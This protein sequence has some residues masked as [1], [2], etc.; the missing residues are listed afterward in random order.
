MRRHD[1]VPVRSPTRRAHDVTRGA[2]RTRGTLRCGRKPGC[3]YRTAGAT[4]PATGEPAARLRV[5]DADTDAGGVVYHGSYLR[6]FK[7]G[8]TEAMRSAGVPLARFAQHKFHLPLIEQTIRYRTPAF[9]DDILLVYVGTSELRRVQVT[10]ECEVRRELDNELVVTGWTLH[11]CM[12]LD[13]GRLCALPAWAVG[14]LRSL[15]QPQAKDSELAGFIGTWHSP[16]SQTCN[17]GPLPTDI[18]NN[19][20]SECSLYSM[21]WDRGFDNSGIRRDELKDELK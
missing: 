7:A 14:S 20:V 21:T 16:R 9:Y 4:H 10:F 3:R 8:R 6:F 15:Q 18:T 11:A 12:D 2:R 19:S 17:V 1:R 13:E 5:L